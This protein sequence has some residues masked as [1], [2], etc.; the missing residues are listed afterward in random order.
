MMESV[1]TQFTTQ[2]ATRSPVLLVYVIGLVLALVFWQRHPR[3]CVL[4]LL[5]MVLA[6]FTSLVSAFLF[7]YLPRAMDEFGWNHHQLGLM[8]SAVSITASILHAGAMGML[9]TAV[10]VGRQSA[11][12]RWPTDDDRT[13][14]PAAG[15]DT[16]VQG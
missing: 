15:P 4:V 14:M 13:A 6:L 7:T 11:L 10:F 2:L 1:L 9:L 16:R 12:A 8:L 5:A 3:P